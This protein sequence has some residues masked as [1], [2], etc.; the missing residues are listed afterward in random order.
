MSLSSLRTLAFI[1]GIFLITLA[2][3]MLV[4][5]GTL[6]VFEQTR[7]INAFLWSSLITFVAGIALV[8]RGRPQEGQLR[9]RD[10]A[11]EINK[12]P[13]MKAILQE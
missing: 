5:V 8:A 3:S 1:N 7:G 10:L 12:Q 2:V 6:L 4:P 11:A 13:G 9:P